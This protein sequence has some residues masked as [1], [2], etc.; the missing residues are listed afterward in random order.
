MKEPVVS[1]ES[2]LWFGETGLNSPWRTSIILQIK[3]VDRN[4]RPSEFC[5]FVL[6]A[7]EYISEQSKDVCPHRAYI[8]AEGDNK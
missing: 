8:L 4:L 7:W 3:V 2:C 1:K 6:G 5:G